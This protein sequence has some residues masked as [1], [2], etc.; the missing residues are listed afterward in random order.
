MICCNSAFEQGNLDLWR[1][2]NAFIIIII[3]CITCPHVRCEDN[4]ITGLQHGVPLRL[5]QWKQRYRREHSAQPRCV[6]G[7]MSADWRLFT[8]FMRDLIRHQ[9][10]ASNA[11]DAV[12]MVAKHCCV[13]MCTS[14][15]RRK[16]DEIISFHSFPRDVMLR[17]KWII[18]IR[19]NEG[20]HF[21]VMCV[22]KSLKFQHRHRCQCFTTL[23][24]LFFVLV[25]RLAH[26]LDY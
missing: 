9:N 11:S 2:I 20:L 19:R 14:D 4:V 17:K 12:N 6:H 5:G 18:A 3:Y 22:N 23:Q 24:Y 21:K 25:N 15:E 1:Y 7:E 8:L 10:E 16:G 26:V 13:P